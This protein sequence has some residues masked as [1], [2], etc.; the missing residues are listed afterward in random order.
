MRVIIID[1]KDA[2]G[3]LASLELAQLRD[4]GHLREDG[5]QPTVDQVHRTFHYV[6]CQWLQ[7]QGA[8]VVR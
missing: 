3:L 6:V 2:R 7:D 5:G 4:N 8:S 1:D